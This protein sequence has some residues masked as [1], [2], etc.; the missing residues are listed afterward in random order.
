L[1]SPEASCTSSPELEHR[2]SAR[3]N[4]IREQLHEVGVC[5]SVVADVVARG[6]QEDEEDDHLSCRERRRSWIGIIRYQS[7]SHGDGPANI[8]A[9][10]RNGAGQIHLPAG[11]SLHDQSVNGCI[12]EVPSCEAGIE[13]ALEQWIGV[14]DVLEDGSE[15]V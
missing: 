7:I 9:Q 10:Q 6:V 3:P 15:V 8:T 14:A 13:L 4:S 11:E 1:N 2:D 5:K 12:D